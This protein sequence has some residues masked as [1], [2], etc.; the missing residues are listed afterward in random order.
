M[1]KLYESKRF[2]VTGIAAAI[3]VILSVFPMYIITEAS[4]KGQFE[5]TAAWSAWAAL[6][7][8]IVAVSANY[9]IKETNR[10]SF[11]GMGGIGINLPKP[12]YKELK[13]HEDM[14]DP[15]DIPL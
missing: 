3:L 11:I 12:K 1:N 4:K 8:G 14:S 6:V 2:I 5:M 10:P 15:E 9:V 7:S 13:N